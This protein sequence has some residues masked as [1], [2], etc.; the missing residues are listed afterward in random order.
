MVV[1]LVS[2][3]LALTRVN[4]LASVGTSAISGMSSMISGIG[5]AFTQRLVPKLI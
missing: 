2:L 1:P 4:T 3:G 5:S